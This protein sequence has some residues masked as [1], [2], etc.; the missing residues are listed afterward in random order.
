MFVVFFLKKKVL[1]LF[2]IHLLSLNVMLLFPVAQHG[3]SYPMLYSYNVDYLITI[4]VGVPLTAI[5]NYFFAAV[6]FSHAARN[7]PEREFSSCESSRPHRHQS[8]DL[9]E[10]CSGC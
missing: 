8:E 1:T 7:I 5:I 9:H 10:E 4:S 2:P 6:S 3:L